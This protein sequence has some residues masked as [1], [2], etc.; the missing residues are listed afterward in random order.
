MEDSVVVELPAG[1]GRKAVSLLQPL[2]SEMSRR[3]RVHDLN[4]AGMAQRIILMVRVPSS[5][6]QQ[7]APSSHQN[8]RG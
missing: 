6:K 2:K 7:K 1:E 8:I 5:S 4:A 3:H